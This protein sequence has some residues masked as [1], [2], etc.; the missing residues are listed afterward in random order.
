VFQKHHLEL[1][2]KTDF[3]ELE[4]SQIEQGPRP[5]IV[6]QPLY[7][8]QLS[9][10]K[11]KKQDLLSLCSSCVIPSL[12]HDFYKAL[13]TSDLPGIR[14]AAVLEDDDDNGIAADSFLD[15]TSVILNLPTGRNETQNQDALQ[16]YPSSSAPPSNQAPKDRRQT[17]KRGRHDAIV[18]TSHIGHQQNHSTNQLAV[19]DIISLSASHDTNHRTTRSSACIRARSNVDNA[20]SITC[21]THPRHRPVTRPT[22]I[23]PLRTKRL[24]R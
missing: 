4:Y 22:S 14:D 1:F 13:P 3:S 19:S 20:V 9:I 17:Q 15:E 18:M 16:L 21:Q 24:L 8:R 2:Y 23:G 5:S 11:L 6:L 10:S 12:Y 7:D